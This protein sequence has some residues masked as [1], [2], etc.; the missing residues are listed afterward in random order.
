LPPRLAEL[1]GQLGFDP[2]AAESATAALASYAEGHSHSPP[3][4]QPRSR[5]ASAAKRQK[6]RGRR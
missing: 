5:K 3:G 6:K 1:W 4:T 2:V